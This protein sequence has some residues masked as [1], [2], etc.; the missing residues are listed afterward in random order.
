MRPW[1]RRAG[2]EVLDNPD[3]RAAPAG[4]LKSGDAM[5]EAINP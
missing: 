2:A 3:D 5:T 4:V 1:A